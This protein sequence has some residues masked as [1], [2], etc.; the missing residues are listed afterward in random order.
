MTQPNKLKTNRL[1][2]VN[3]KEYDKYMIHDNGDRP[4]T[5]YINANKK[6]DTIIFKNTYTADDDYKKP[7]EKFIGRLKPKTIFIG[8]SPKCE[9]TKFSA[10]Y[11]KKFYGN[12]ILLYMGANKYIH[13][14]RSITKFTLNNSDKIIDYVS[15]VG[16]NDV[17]YPVGLGEKYVY[18]FFHKKNV[19]YIKREDIDIHNL[20]K[21][22][23]IIDQIFKYEPFFID[24]TKPLIL[25]ITLKDFK[26]IM[27]THIKNIKK[28][29]LVN[30]CK[31]F[32]VTHSGSKTELIARLETVRDFKFIK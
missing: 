7:I 21:I 30:I 16:N 10:G 13:F 8:K 20:K 26:N 9:M 32:E 23:L 12:T 29:D 25:P 17:P 6:N 2:N 28:D 15:P 3:L 1:K 27:Q 4:F 14:S 22:D 31:M 18:N 24:V 5:L 11:G 19:S